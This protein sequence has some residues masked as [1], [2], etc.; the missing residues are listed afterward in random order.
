MKTL[1]KYL[2]RESIGPFLFGLA[3]ITLVLIMDFL[4]DIMNL[5]IE[6]GVKIPLVMEL[7][8][9]NLAWML[10]LA[11]PMA[12]LVAVLMVFG[13]LSSDNE[14]TACK[15]CGISYYRLLLP[16]VGAATI[17]TIVMVWF[18]DRV[19]PESNHRARM[20]M[21]DIATKK[22]TWSLEENIFLDYFEGYSIRVKTVARKTSEISDIIIIQTTGIDRII[23][24]RRGNMYFSPDETTLMLELE[25]G[26]IL[27]MDQK[28][29]EGYTRTQFEK[30]T[31]AIP[32]ASSDMQRTQESMRGDREMSVEMMRDQNKGRQKRLDLIYHEADSL[33]AAL[34]GNTLNIGNP[35]TQYIK[36]SKM[37][38][39]DR[40]LR[41][42]KE[43]HAK[44]IFQSNNAINY[45]RE[46]NSMNVEIEKKFSI[47]FACISFVLIGAPLGSL[48][49]KGGFAT[50]IAL[51]IFFFIIYWAF[52]IIGEQMGDSGSLPAFWAMWLGDIVVGGAGIILTIMFI[53][54]SSVVSLLDRIKSSFIILL[55]RRYRNTQ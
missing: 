2:L 30:Q 49:R 29:P 5:I 43:A 54:Q 55:P 31:I 16:M 8:A 9:V 17:L 48:A 14:L 41:K 23:T 15:A 35:G 44:M 7:F 42:V 24:S 39:I 32:G 3:V 53:R 4:V 19:L 45:A 25:D 27:E 33:S 6:K 11:V 46:V 21:T 13:R 1:S 28:N 50:G 38:G 34:V 37:A 20:L 40:A 51:S 12:V 18:N 52:L 36:V 10:A 22:P 47:P 26:E